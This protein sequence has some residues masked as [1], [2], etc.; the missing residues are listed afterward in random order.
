MNEKSKEQLKIEM[1]T[2]ATVL[3]QAALLSAK[4]V[5]EKYSTHIMINGNLYKVSIEA[6]LA[7]AIS[8]LTRLPRS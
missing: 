1:L 7:P 6:T 4:A 2:S 8:E 5:R 3:L